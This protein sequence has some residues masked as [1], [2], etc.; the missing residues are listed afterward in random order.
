MQ[1]RTA[2]LGVRSVDN[3]VDYLPSMIESL[4][5]AILSLDLLDEDDLVNALAECRQ[6]LANPGTAFTMWTLAQVWGWKT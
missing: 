4:R 3:M 6:H 1:Y 5:A 2:I